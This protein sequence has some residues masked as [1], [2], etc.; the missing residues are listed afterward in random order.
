[1]RTVVVANGKLDHPKDAAERLKGADFIIAA[2]GGLQHCLEL[3]VTPDLLVGDLD[4]VSAETLEAVQGAGC[5]ISRYPRRK[6]ATDLE[7][8][9]VEAKAR[10]CEQLTILGAVGGR[11]DQSLANLHLLANPEFAGL[12]LE[13][14]DGPQSAR[15]ARPGNPV[16][17]DGDP[18]DTV[19]LIPIGGDAVGVRTQGLEYELAGGVLNHA[20]SRGVSNVMTDGSARVEVSQGALLCLVLHG[21]EAKIGTEIEGGF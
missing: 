19:S 18:G 7:L 21:G 6:D 8:A 16:R 17:L 3:G 4:S 5:E 10:G 2:D 1:M 9:L 15:L 11:W 14:A 12:Q 20:S 13:I